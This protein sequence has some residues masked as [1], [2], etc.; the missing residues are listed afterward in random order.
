MGVNHNVVYGI[1]DTGACTT[2]MD[3]SMASALG[4]E[5]RYQNNGDCGSYT[6]PGS[7]G[8]TQYAAVAALPVRIQFGPD[9]SFQLIGIRVVTHPVPL[10]LIGADILRGGRGPTSWNFNGLSYHTS[11]EGKVTGNLVFQKGNAVAQCPLAHCPAHNSN[12]P[13]LQAF[14][15]NPVA[16]TFSIGPPIVGDQCL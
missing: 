12:N 10:F 14:S 16:Q 5:L 11:M 15:T 8:S 7:A 1:V 13:Q 2:V 3:E 9:V 6:T 4:I